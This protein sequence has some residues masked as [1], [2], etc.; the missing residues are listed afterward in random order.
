MKNSGGRSEVI[1]DSPPSASVA[2]S[3]VGSRTA[4]IPAAQRRRKVCCQTGPL[5]GY[6]RRGDDDACTLSWLPVQRVAAGA[7]LVAG[8]GGSRGPELAD[9]IRTAS[10]S[11]GISP[12][13]RPRAATDPSRIRALARA[14]CGLPEPMT[15]PSVGALAGV[16]W[17]LLRRLPSVVALVASLGCSER[18]RPEDPAASAASP[19]PIVSGPGLAAGNPG[20]AGL[21]RHPSV[22]FFESF[23]RGT[24]DDLTGRWS[25]L[26]NAGGMT[27]VS[28]A[29]VP[30]ETGRAIRLTATEGHDTGALLFRRL[31]PGHDRLFVR[32]YVKYEDADY[33]HSG[34][35]VG[36]TILPPTCRAACAAWRLPGSKPSRSPWNAPETESSTSTTIGRR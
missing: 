28:A 9:Q 15:L 1:R 26:R 13:D 21:E 30:G 34:L 24:L 27:L 22:V 16:S 33:H 31:E 20:D 3:A 8:P 11:L 10:G 25:H 7:G 35:N 29:P 12:R 32:V 19:V 14:C 23:D 4:L 36:G 2:R 6:Q 18:W 17:R 5:R